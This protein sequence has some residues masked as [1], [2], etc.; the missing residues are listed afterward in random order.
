MPQWVNIH[1]EGFVGFAKFFSTASNVRG[2]VCPGKTLT[3]IG[4]GASYNGGLVAMNRNHRVTF[5][6]DAECV[7]ELGGNVSFSWGTFFLFSLGKMSW[8]FRYR[9]PDTGNMRAWSG[10][11]WDF[12]WGLGFGGGYIALVVS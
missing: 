9:D 12:G 7:Y 1:I 6:N 3:T 2:E 5:P 8:D 4:A 11:E 10:S